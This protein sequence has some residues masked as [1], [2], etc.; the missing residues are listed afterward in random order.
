MRP[1]SLALEE[2]QVT[3][4]LCVRVCVRSALSPRP[5]RTPHSGL[6][7]SAT[8]PRRR[9]PFDGRARDQSE[10]SRCALS[11][12]FVRCRSRGVRP[13]ASISMCTPSCC[14]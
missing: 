8:K 6:R 13:L 7:A 5:D 2:M 3:A 14:F 9:S 10:P 11:D 4:F 1:G 12:E